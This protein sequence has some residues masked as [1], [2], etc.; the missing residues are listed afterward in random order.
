M[1]VENW[2]MPVI[3]VAALGHPGG[4]LILTIKSNGD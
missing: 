1:F 2:L 3:V 4:K